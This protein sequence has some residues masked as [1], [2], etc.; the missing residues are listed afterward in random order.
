M[1]AALR[2][3]PLI[4]G[5]AQIMALSTATWFT[6]GVAGIGA[7]ALITLVKETVTRRRLLRRK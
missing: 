4:G 7:I 5:I 1:S 3:P 6:G 2:G